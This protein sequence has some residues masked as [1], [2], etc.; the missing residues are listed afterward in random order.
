MSL[1]CWETRRVTIANKDTLSAMY[2][3]WLSLEAFGK[4]KYRQVRSYKATL[5]QYAGKEGDCQK[6]FYL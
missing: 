3:Y 5:S 2:P 4:R 1:K 6:V